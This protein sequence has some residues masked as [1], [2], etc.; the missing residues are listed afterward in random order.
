[1]RGLWWAYS[2]YVY[3]YYQLLVVDSRLEDL[4]G[5]LGYRRTQLWRTIERLDGSISIP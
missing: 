3:Y 5:T 1:M 2:Q 4:A